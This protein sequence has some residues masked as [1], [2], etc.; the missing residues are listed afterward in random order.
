[1]ELNE[2]Q[3][4][5]FKKRVNHQFDDE[6]RDI[7]ESQK[8][9]LIKY[10]GSQYKRI[11]RALL[12]ANDFAEI[13]GETRED[14]LNIDSVM[15]KG[16][17]IRLYRGL[18]DIED[19]LKI[20]NV[21]VHK[22]FCSASKNIDISRRFSKGGCCILTFLLPPNIKRYDFT[23]EKEFE[24]LIERN[25]QFTISPQ[26]RVIYFVKVYDAVISP[27]V[28]PHIDKALVKKS[29]QELDILMIAEEWKNTLPERF[30]QVEVDALLETKKSL[31]FAPEVYK[32]IRM[33]LVFHAKTL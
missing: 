32:M 1:M 20:S 18:K 13:G 14:I 21:L 3:L 12:E 30:S 16:D 5:E 4:S 10:K 11:N 2:K 33:M 23:E 24:V 15:K 22:N 26:Y 6:K 17:E 7:T 31:G 19:L 25:V 28:P 29:S 8:K 9:S 27:Y